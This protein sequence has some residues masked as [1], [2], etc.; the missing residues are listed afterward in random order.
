MKIYVC[1]YD[2]DYEGCTIPEAA[3]KREEDAKAWCESR[4]YS[5]YEELELK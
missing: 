5:E 3:F 1:Y 4:S 2:W